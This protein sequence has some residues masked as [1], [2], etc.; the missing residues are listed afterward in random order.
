[1]GTIKAYFDCFLFFNVNN[2]SASSSSPFFEERIERLDKDGTEPTS[3]T[4]RGIDVRQS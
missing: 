2:D 4:C 1:M 3:T